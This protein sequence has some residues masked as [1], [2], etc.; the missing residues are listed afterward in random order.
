MFARGNAS[1][2]S[3]SGLDN[4]SL[5]GGELFLME[6]DVLEKLDGLK[7]IDA[8]SIENVYI[9]DNPLLSFCVVNSIC[10]FLASPNGLIDIYNNAEGCNSAEEIQDACSAGIEDQGSEAL[11]SIFPNPA[12][13]ELYISNDTGITIDG[14]KITNQQGQQIL[15]EN[16]IPS[17][18][19]ISILQP[20]LY[21]IELVS[22]EFIIREKLIVN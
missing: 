10:E 14:V 4:L 20:G 7:N 19:N 5:L 12:K 6:N 1:L 2:T 18:I 15:Y 3:F 17:A 11:I 13:N 21:V 8:A 9:Y 22:D 16:E